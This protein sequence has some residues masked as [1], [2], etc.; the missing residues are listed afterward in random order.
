MNEI[1]EIE[2]K[3]TYKF[4]LFLDGIVCKDE[5]IEICKNL[6]IRRII[7][8]GSL[9][10]LEIKFQVIDSS[11]KLFPLTELSG[12]FKSD[13]DWGSLS[14]TEISEKVYIYPAILRLF[15]LGAVFLHS[16][17]IEPYNNTDSKK[18]RIIDMNYAS[19]IKYRKYYEI[20][21]EDKEVLEKIMNILQKPVTDVFLP[22]A[23]E[24]V[25]HVFVALEMYNNA[26]LNI[27]TMEGRVRYYPSLIAFLVGALEALYLTGE[28]EGSITRR[29]GQ[30]AAI[31]LKPF[32]NYHPQEIYNKVKDAYNIRSKYIH[33][34]A[35]PKKFKEK[36]SLEVLS[37][38]IF[39]F[40]RISILIFLQLSII[41]NENDKKKNFLFE[42]L[43]HSL[44]DVKKACKLNN[45]LKTCF[46]P[47]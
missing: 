42:D 8:P 25:N 41:D 14:K 39:E 36:E 32:I 30:R 27:G 13:K 17:V 12:L 29:L 35:L 10:N 20:N 5:E 3:Y 40:V 31:V 21:K 16:I 22:M 44:L 26:F 46:I 11:P 19:L 34:D 24:S 23:K 37:I 7:D 18:E 9:T 28:N 15:R 1:D 2:E 33:G 47:K 38:A 45:R 4:K 43:D 6:I